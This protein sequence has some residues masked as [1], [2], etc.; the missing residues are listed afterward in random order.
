M[1]NITTTKNSK[2]T[3][4][5]IAAFAPAPVVGKRG[6]GNNQS[7]G[8]TFRWGQAEEELLTKLVFSLNCNRTEAVKYAL[9]IAAAG[10]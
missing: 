4:A 10:I 9:R 2:A 5:T 1:R 8:G 7:L 6:Y 3:K